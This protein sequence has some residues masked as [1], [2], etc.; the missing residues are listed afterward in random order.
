MTSETTVPLIYESQIHSVSI[1]IRWQR[2]GQNYV[3]TVPWIKNEQA[4]LLRWD[5][6]HGKYQVSSCL[7]ADTHFL[8]ET[9]DAMHCAL[10]VLREHVSGFFRYLSEGG[11]R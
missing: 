8:S 5:E 4:F 10:L 6:D 3:G 7:T 1:A 2:C 11:V 9:N